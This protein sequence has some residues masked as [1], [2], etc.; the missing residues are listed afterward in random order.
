MIKEDMETYKKS[1]L[2]RVISHT[3]IEDLTVQ[4]VD[5]GLGGYFLRW[6][7]AD[8]Q[9][10]SR[11]QPLYGDPVALAEARELFPEHLPFT[12]MPVDAT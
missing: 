3:N 7:S 11:S 9:E 10:L 8:D 2:L 1:P 5:D 6:L 4:L 12:A